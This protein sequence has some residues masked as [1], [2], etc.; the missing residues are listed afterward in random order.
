[1]PIMA[2]GIAA[3]PVA[4]SNIIASAFNSVVRNVSAALGV[5][6]LT[7]I[8]TIQQ[9]QQLAGR[10]APP[11]HFVKRIPRDCHCAEPDG[12]RK[13]RAARVKAT[14]VRGTVQITVSGEVDLSNAA[15]LGSELCRAISSQPRA[16]LVDLTDLTYLDSAGIR[17]LFTL[18]SWLE[19]LR[20]MLKLIVPVDSPIRRLIELS[21][22]E[23]L[24]HLRP[25]SH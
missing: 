7:A 18:A 8:L 5:A 9:T 17:S 24:A 15:V 4:Q 3:I 20:I 6:G 12:H 16:V 2:G 13:R 21:G 23:S 19:P 11:S 14:T 10:A 1:M 22:L 25:E